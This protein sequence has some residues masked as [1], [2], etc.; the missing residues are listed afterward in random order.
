MYMY[1]HYFSLF[2]ELKL[3][4][5]FGVIETEKRERENER[6]TKTTQNKT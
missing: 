6:N 3:V 4:N 2:F 1:A 5:S